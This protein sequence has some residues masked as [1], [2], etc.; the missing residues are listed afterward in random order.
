M[1]ACGLDWTVRSDAGDASPVGD[2]GIDVIADTPIGVDVADTGPRIDAPL[3]PDAMACA[4]L[5]T[6]LQAKKAK[7]QQCQISDPTAQCTS[8]VDDECGCAV[9]VRFPTAAPTTDYTNAIAAY[10]ATCGS[11]PVASCTCPPLG[12]PAGWKCLANG[13]R[14]LCRPP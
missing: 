7:A 6:D 10:L 11:P 4:A 13:N 5:A 12:V 8:K 14:E 1:A 2:G 3:S 9:I